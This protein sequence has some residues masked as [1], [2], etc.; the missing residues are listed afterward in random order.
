MTR[1]PFPYRS[2]SVALVASGTAVSM[3]TGWQSARPSKQ[4]TAPVSVQQ[5]MDLLIDPAAD[6]LWAS[7]GTQV[8]AA[9]SKEHAPR[10]P[11][12]WLRVAGFAESLAAG[13]RRLQRP[14]LP[15]GSN[16]HSRLAD[17]NTPGTRTAVQIRANIDSDPAKFRAAAVRLEEVSN[18]A[19]TAA[20]NHDVPGLL[21]A[22]EALDAACESC[23]A[24]YWYPRTPALSLP[25]PEVF[26]TKI[27]RP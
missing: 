11:A 3:G 14:G 2:L 17:A 7:A 12:Q 1:I 15:V 27:L 4:S 8:T 21:I 20:R 23:H 26:K 18:Q 22:G 24:A 6:A 10:T 5:T 13:A 16:G 19:L 25:S 9:G